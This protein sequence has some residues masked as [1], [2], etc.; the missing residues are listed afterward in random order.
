MINLAQSPIIFNRLRLSTHSI[1]SIIG[2][3]STTFLLGPV[4]CITHDVS[5]FGDFDESVAG[6][7]QG[8]TLILYWIKHLLE[9]ASNKIL[10]LL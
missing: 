8:S 6:D 10:K 1:I 9:V 2:L 4:G 5:F 7:Y 3:L